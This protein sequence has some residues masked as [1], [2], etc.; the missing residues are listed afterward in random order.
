MVEYLPT[1][2]KTNNNNKKPKNNTDFMMLDLATILDKIP[3]VQAAKA[4]T[5]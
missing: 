4:N 5:H 3:K 2:F 1:V